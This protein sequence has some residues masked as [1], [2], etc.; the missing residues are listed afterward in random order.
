MEDDWVR[1]LLEDAKDLKD[2]LDKWLL[3]G[4]NRWE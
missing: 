2:N 1:K 3:E 4:W